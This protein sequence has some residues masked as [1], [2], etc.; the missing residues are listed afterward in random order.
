MTSLNDLSLLSKEWEQQFEAAYPLELEAAT[1]PRVQVVSHFSRYAASVAALPAAERQKIDQIARFIAGGLRSGKESIRT[2]RLTGHADL[3]TPRRPAFE[4]QVARAR[5]QDVIAALAWALNRIERTTGRAVPPYSSRIAWEI[6]SAGATRLVVPNPRTE[7]DRSRNRRVEISLL[8]N[9]SSLP[10]SVSMRGPKFAVSARSSIDVSAGAAI[11]D[12][13]R[14]A[15]NDALRYNDPDLGPDLADRRICVSAVAS[16]AAQ[17]CSSTNAA[18]RASIP[19]RGVLTLDPRTG[20][21]CYSRMVGSQFLAGKDY[22]PPLTGATRANCCTKGFP[23]SPKTLS[24]LP[25]GQY[26]VL[27]YQPGP[28]KKLVDRLKCLLDRGCVVPVGVLSGICDD[29]PDLSGICKP[30]PLQNKWRDCWEH[31]LLIIGYDVDRFVFW[32][33]AEASA[34]GPV[35][36]G[37]DNHY[38]GFLYYDSTNHRLTTATTHP[39]VADALEVDSSGFHTQGAP[40]RH[41]QKRYQVTSMWN[42]LPWKSPGA[43]CSLT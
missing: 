5:A 16:K 39:G 26:L 2:V 40:R 7:L 6:Q 24:S 34:M 38:F 33:S 41:A 12:F 10:Q 15:P 9:E 3:D 27:K 37:K 22:L 36:R 17:L 14:R 28:L 8:P 31:W 23:C 42:G 13:L 20:G 35:R 25:A 4:H 21:R 1:N 43:P 30:I 32:D 11:D 19:C 18:D 29:K